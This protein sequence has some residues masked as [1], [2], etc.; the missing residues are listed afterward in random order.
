MNGFRKIAVCLLLA[1]GFAACDKE[2]TPVA[3]RVEIEYTYRYADFVRIDTEAGH[4]I[5]YMIHPLKKLSVTLD[6]GNYTICSGYFAIEGGRRFFQVKGGRTT[7]IL[8]DDLLIP[9]V[10]YE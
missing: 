8:Y 10:N 9:T 6:A 7:R 5:Y 1:A 4:E 2:E 3:G